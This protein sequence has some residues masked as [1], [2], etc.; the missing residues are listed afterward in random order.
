MDYQCIRHL[1]H[2]TK[3]A[4]TYL[5]LALGIQKGG[6][7]TEQD[8]YERLSVMIATSGGDHVKAFMDALVSDREKGGGTVYQSI[9]ARGTSCTKMTEYLSLEGGTCDCRNCF[10]KCRGKTYQPERDACVMQWVIGDSY[11]LELLTA[12]MKKTEA[13]MKK[14]FLTSPVMLLNQGAASYS[15][16]VWE[17]FFEFL[18][19]GDPPIISYRKQ[20]SGYESL[21]PEYMDAYCERI[22]NAVREDSQIL[23]DAYKDAVM[24]A[25]E[26]TLNGIRTASDTREDAIR[27]IKEA[28]SPKEANLP[29]RKLPPEPKPE[30][31]TTIPV[32]KKAEKKESPVKAV[33]APPTIP[34]E[35]KADAAASPD[36]AAVTEAPKETPKEPGSILERR[37]Q[38]FLQKEQKAKQAAGVLPEIHKEPEKFPFENEAMLT[39][40]P[41][42]SEEADIVLFTEEDFTDLFYRLVQSRCHYLPMEIVELPEQG[43]A[44]LLYLDRRYY[45]V[46]EESFS[47]LAESRIFTTAKPLCFLP[48]AIL[49]RFPQLRKIHSLCIAW[50]SYYMSRPYTIGAEGTVYDILHV[51]RKSGQS[52]MHFLLEHYFSVYEEIRSKF[53][54]PE[55]D[56]Y[57]SRIWEAVYRSPAYRMQCFHVLSERK[58][59]VLFAFN[60][61]DYQYHYS[62]HS[63]TAGNGYVKYRIIIHNL[64]AGSM[65]EII[66]GLAASYC[67]H[68]LFQSLDI[69]FVGTIDNRNELEFI[70]SISCEHE[71]LEIIHLD[72][73]RLT[74]HL[75]E[76]KADITIQRENQRE[77]K[78]ELDERYH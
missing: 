20:D 10:R 49:G 26:D 34:K 36:A 3:D 50:H 31:V 13:A 17:C 48:F 59:P 61:R 11:I 23:P 21:L 29:N 18:A 57:R 6:G 43:S 45:L 70:T 1:Q 27:Y 62:L 60:G 38:E 9:S 56:R 64:P 8:A 35:P 2:V 67:S 24:Q 63:L 68:S 54:E 32:K 25:L 30:A 53:R 4:E 47:M 66:S 65:G 44:I 14:G 71:F 46:Y 77:R 78:G 28:L 5:K 33:E 12:R 72:F 22:R 76:G 52:M 75:L 7:E 37:K 74:E 42:E 41:Y 51:R 15:F 39:V 73:L 55:R 58:E 40:Y 16:P 69:R 19:A